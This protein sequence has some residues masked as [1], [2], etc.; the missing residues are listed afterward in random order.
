MYA[1]SGSA[2][3]N[4]AGLAAAVCRSGRQ[5]TTGSVQTVAVRGRRRGL[6][7]VA[8]VVAG[9][10]VCRVEAGTVG[11]VET[12]SVDGTVDLDTAAAEAVAAEAVVAVA[13]VAAFA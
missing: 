4:R 8:A 1:S 13:G 2:A 12:E 10:V 11:M 3:P 5:A 7:T 9:V 6:Q